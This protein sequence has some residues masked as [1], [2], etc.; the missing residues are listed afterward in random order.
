MD[1]HLPTLD[2][3][4]AKRAA[5]SSGFRL[6]TEAVAVRKIGRKV[7]SAGLAWP[8]HKRRKAGVG[9]RRIHLHLAPEQPPP[10]TPNCNSNLFGSGFSL[11]R[12]RPN[13]PVSCTAGANQQAER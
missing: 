3:R 11:R 7:G 6:L 5:T 2:A 1:Y 13:L 12:Q 4:V 10:F 9:E 8:R